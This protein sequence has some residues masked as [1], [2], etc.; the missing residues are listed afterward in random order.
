[1]SFLLSVF[2]SALLDIVLSSSVLLS[3]CMDGKD[4]PCWRVTMYIPRTP[5]FTDLFFVTLAGVGIACTRQMKRK[6]RVYFIVSAG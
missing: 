3:M 2:I 5:A 1:M 6:E 4:L